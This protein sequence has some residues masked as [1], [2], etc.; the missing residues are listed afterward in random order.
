VFLYITPCARPHLMQIYTIMNTQE[1]YEMIEDR[2]RELGLSQAQLGAL[3]FGRAD[4]SGVQNLKRGSSP[5]HDKLSQIAQAL[6][7]ELYFGP[8]RET[9]TVKQ[10]MLN[11]KDFAQIPL[12]EATLS[13]GHGSLNESDLVI[14]HLAFRRDWL[15]RIGLAASNASLARVTGD[16][17]L[18]TIAD[19]DLVLIDT[20]KRDPPQ[21]SGSGKHPVKRPIYAV[22]IEGQARVKR[23][24]QPSAGTLMLISDNPDYAPEVLT[25]TDAENLQIIGKVMWWGHTVRE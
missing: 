10:V 4:N 18:P 11:N 3:A 19:N 17:M 13:A 14:D 12:H 22:L 7:F 1:L 2:R 6:G 16:S 9:G 25:G 15:Q 20:T 21:V 23:L 8:P 24:L 5:T